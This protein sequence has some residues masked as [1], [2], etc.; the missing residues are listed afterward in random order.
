MFEKFGYNNYVWNTYILYRN[1]FKQYWI[2][3]NT[4]KDT[5]VIAGL[6]NFSYLHCTGEG[7]NSIGSPQWCKIIYSMRLISPKRIVFMF[8]L[9]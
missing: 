2:K 9:L 4:L 7:H 3:L 1:I 5:N 8:Y 6:S